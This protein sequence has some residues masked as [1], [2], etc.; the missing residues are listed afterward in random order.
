[1][2]VTCFRKQRGPSEVKELRRNKEP[3]LTAR[4]K[5][6]NDQYYSFTL[7]PFRNN[8]TAQKVDVGFK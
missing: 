6:M 8:Y 1:M 3:H 7:E 5:A 4:F 2:E